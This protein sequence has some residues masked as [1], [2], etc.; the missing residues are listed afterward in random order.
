V[1]R[2]RCAAMVAAL[3][4][5]AAAAVSVGP[6]APYSGREGAMATSSRAAS[7]RPIQPLA[8]VSVDSAP[9]LE[10]RAL[11]PAKTL[12]PFALAPILFT[13]LAANWRT[14]LVRR[15]ADRGAPVRL[16]RRHSIVLRAPPLLASP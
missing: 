2:I 12:L 4:V 5:A 8:A 14:S 16:T 11:R 13:V 9:G 10:Q 7:V 15:R 1:V 6:R 3:A